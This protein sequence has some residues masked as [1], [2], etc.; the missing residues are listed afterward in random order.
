MPEIGVMGLRCD[1]GEQCLLA[2]AGLFIARQQG[3]LV[4]CS[5]DSVEAVL[6]CFADDGFD[7]ARV[8]GQM[9][10]GSGLRVI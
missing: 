1:L 4:S 3:L 6:A 10:E 7:A 2:A 5:P 8:I 9:T